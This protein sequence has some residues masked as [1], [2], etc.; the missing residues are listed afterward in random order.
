MEKLKNF[1]YHYKFRTVFCAFLA[2]VIA[3]GVYSAVTKETYD[4]TVYLYMSENVGGD[5]E[6]A[7]KKTVEKIYSDNGI[8]KSVGIKNLSYDPTSGDSEG[9]LAKASAL[10]GEFSLKEDFVFITDEYRLKELTE[11]EKLENLFLKDSSL[12][13]KFDNSAFSFKGGNFEKTF[14]EFLNQNGVLVN[15]MPELYL[16]VINCD[17]KDNDNYKSALEL[18]ELIKQKEK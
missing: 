3:V 13:D 11:N 15:E 2:L 4:I 12:F 7:L 1:W 14:K 6:D 16:S 18:A 10:A 9:N 5:V 17:D 8:E